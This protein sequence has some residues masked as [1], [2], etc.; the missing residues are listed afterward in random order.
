MPLVCGKCGVVANSSEVASITPR[1]AGG[2]RRP[3]RRG[4]CDLG[5]DFELKPSAKPKWHQKWRTAH[6]REDKRLRCVG[7]ARLAGA[8]AK[9]FFGG[10]L[11]SITYGAHCLGLDTA[12]RRATSTMAVAACGPRVGRAHKLG[13]SLV[14]APSGNVRAT[15]SV[16]SAPLV[17]YAKEWWRS[18]VAAPA[19]LATSPVRLVGAFQA[20]SRPYPARG[21]RHITACGPV[22]AAIDAAAAVVW[23]SV[24][25]VDG[26]TPRATT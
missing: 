17:L 24:S 23:T 25:A 21:P 6:G 3:L 22:G 9:L 15:L 14:L 11:P 19:T 26:T 20:T 7:G 12:A 18:N 10:T 8:I 1:F 13:I 2:V 5:L 4:V 16:L